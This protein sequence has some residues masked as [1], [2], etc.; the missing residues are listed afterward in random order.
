MNLRRYTPADCASWDKFVDES[1]NGTALL[2][3]SYMDYHADRF[4]DHSYIFEDKRGEILALLPAT[5][6]DDALSSHAGLTYG[7]LIMS[8]YSSGT[9]P[10]DLFPPLLDEIRR[11]GLKRLIYKPVPHIYH[12]QG[13]EEDLYAL[14]RL[15][16]HLT[17]RNLA[18]AINLTDPVPSS[19]LGKRACKRQRKNSILVSETT[20]INTFWPIVVDDRRQRH[21]VVPV[22]TATELNRLK[23]DNPAYIRFFTASLPD[24]EILGGAVV[25]VDRGVIHLQYAACSDKGKSLYA[26]DVIYHEIIYNIIPGMK[27][28][29]FG[30][31]NEDAGRYLNE[32]MVYH[33]EEFGGRSICYDTYEIS[34]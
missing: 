18:T 29:D 28:F 34:L 7:G 25:Y 31:S 26:T 17:I 10:L 15:N 16:A 21:N 6:R 32:G 24:G 33:K 1:K 4:P 3:R 12:R 8:P 20:D 14:F 13:S 19:R 9:L 11:E 23:K 22:H 30:I 5:L 27:W 2:H